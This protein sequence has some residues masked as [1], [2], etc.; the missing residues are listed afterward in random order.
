M[1]AGPY[2]KFARREALCRVQV[3][4]NGL[5]MQFMATVDQAQN[6]TDAMSKHRSELC[7]LIDEEVSS[8]LRWLPCRRLWD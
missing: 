8:D 5:L 7:I 3:A 4:T 2:I 1:R 6:F